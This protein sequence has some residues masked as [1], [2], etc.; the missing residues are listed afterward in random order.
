MTFTSAKERFAVYVKGVDDSNRD[1]QQTSTITLSIDK[2]DAKLPKSLRTAKDKTVTV[3]TVDDDVLAN[4]AP[5]PGWPPAI[6]R[7]SSRSI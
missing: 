5:S 3:V 1:G 2:T 4:Q 7:R 6:S